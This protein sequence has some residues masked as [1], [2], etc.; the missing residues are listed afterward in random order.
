MKHSLPALVSAVLMAA[1]SVTLAPAA[2]AK[3]E[4]KSEPINPTADPFPC[5]S[6]VGGG[7][8]QC[9]ANGCR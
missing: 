2:L 4:P 6:G 9:D 1:L 5:N 8:C 3:S 7:R